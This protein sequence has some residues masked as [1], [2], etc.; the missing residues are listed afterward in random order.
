MKSN[1]LAKYNKIRNLK[2]I[3]AFM[4]DMLGLLSAF[5]PVAG[6]TTDIIW[7]PISGLLIFVLFPKRKY[8]AIGGMV[9][10]MLPFTDIVP[11]ACLTWHSVY[12]KDKEKTLSEFVSSRIIEEQQVAEILGKYK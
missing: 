10:E 2:L 9:E 12:I 1:L 4:I 6:G 3:F 5:I 8:M 11:T 7:G